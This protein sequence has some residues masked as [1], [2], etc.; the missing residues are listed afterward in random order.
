MVETDKRWKRPQTSRQ[1]QQCYMTFFNINNNN[2]SKQMLYKPLHKI[3]Y[4]V[5]I[6]K[7]INPVIYYF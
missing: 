2:D 1:T 5:G 7:M 6:Q 3:P 4:N